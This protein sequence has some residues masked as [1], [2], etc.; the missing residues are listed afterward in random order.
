ML[1]KLL[2]IFAV[3]VVLH[4]LIPPL[5]V[6]G[7]FFDYLPLFLAILMA[8]WITGD[9]TTVISRSAPKKEKE[10]M[11][12]AIDKSTD[13]NIGL[14]KAIRL[15]FGIGRKQSDIKFHCD[16]CGERIERKYWLPL[17]GFIRLRGKTA[18]CNNKIPRV[19]FIIEVISFTSLTSIIILLRHH[20]LWAILAIFVVWQSVIWVACMIKYKMRFS[21]KITIPFM[22]MIL[23][24]YLPLFFLMLWLH[25]SMVGV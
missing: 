4:F 25:D 22:L 3:L 18:C 2:S 12:D 7:L 23:L 15:I 13:T 10:V 20:P 16:Y 1:I 11:Q 5:N 17:I 6:F 24:I 21:V 19:F 9:A 8:Y 14:F